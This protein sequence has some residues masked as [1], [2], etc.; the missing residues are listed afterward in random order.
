MLIVLLWFMNDR[1]PAYENGKIF[2]WVQNYQKIYLKIL[3]YY[4]SSIQ[5]LKIHLRFKTWMILIFTNNTIS[6][7][8]GKNIACEK[9]IF[10]SDMHVLFLI[11]HLL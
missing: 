3:K 11:A 7:Y 5:S 1:F 8:G 9:R 10:L 4:T 6:K 2:Q